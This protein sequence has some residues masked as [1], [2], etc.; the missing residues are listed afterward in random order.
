MEMGEGR[1]GPPLLRFSA[2][3]SKFDEQQKG[4][5]HSAD[6]ET[7]GLG[8]GGNGGGDDPGIWWC[9]CGAGAGKKEFQFLSVAVKPEDLEAYGLI[10]EIIGRLP[11]IAPLD[12]LGVADLA[13]ILQSTKGSLIQ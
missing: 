12:V 6:G 7:A 3:E 10:P 13:R 5:G 2:E 11:V 9:S 1:R 8:N 4:D